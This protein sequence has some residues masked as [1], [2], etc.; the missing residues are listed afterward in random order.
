MMK[1]KLLR[2]LMAKRLTKALREKRRW[3]GV[4]V[5]PDCTSREDVEERIAALASTTE[6]RPDIR[7]MDFVN[8]A[9]GPSSGNNGSLELNGGL[10]ILRIHLKDSPSLRP[11]LQS[12]DALQ[13]HGMSSVTTSGKIRL[14]RQRLGLPTPKRKR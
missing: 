6:P 11:P 5:E 3:L 12:Q 10:A 13:R 7:L 2:R 9:S 1:R 4:V 8:A 14:V